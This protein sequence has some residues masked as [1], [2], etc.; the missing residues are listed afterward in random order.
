MT[1]NNVAKYAGA[2]IVDA[3]TIAEFLVDIAAG[4]LQAYKREKPG[5]E[6]VE[7]E[8]P[9]AFA[10]HGEAARL[11]PAL[12]ESFQKNTLTLAQIRAILPLA[13]KL[14]EVLQE[15]EVFYED[16]READIVRIVTAIRAVAQYED[17]PALLAGFE[18]TIEYRAQYGKKAAAT[19]RQNEAA[20]KTPELAE[21]TPQPPPQSS[22]PPA[23]SCFDPTHH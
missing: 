10:L 9:A 13:M 2:T 20:K 12:L 5:I 6:E 22:P 15:S 3:Q 4:E 17:S 1:S 23:H 11:H 14:V 8:L 21:P 18:K 19:R 16:A 7:V